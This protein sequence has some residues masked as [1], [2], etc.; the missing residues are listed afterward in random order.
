MEITL[1]LDEKALWTQVIEEMET[2]IALNYCVF[3]RSPS[4]DAT[5][6][7]T[8]TQVAKPGWEETEP[9]LIGSCSWKLAE[10]GD[11]VKEVALPKKKVG[12]VLR[13]RS[14]ALSAA[15]TV[16]SGVNER[17]S[18]HS[19]GRSWQVLGSAEAIQR[20]DGLTNVTK[21]DDR[22]SLAPDRNFGSWRST[23]SIS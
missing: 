10:T 7:V 2:N 8:F 13:M 22:P 17:R 21:A 16:A 4:P 12:G 20:L 9:T 5:V 6:Q 1:L 18:V 23:T 15:S 3:L 14:F 11:L 19:D